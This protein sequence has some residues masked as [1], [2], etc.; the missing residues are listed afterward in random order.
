MWGGRPCVSFRKFPQYKLDSKIVGVA[1]RSSPLQVWCTAICLY[2]IQLCS[3]GRG[4]PPL[5]GW[6]IVSPIVGTFLACRLGRCF[7]ILPYAEVS[8]GDPHPSRLSAFGRTQFAPTGLVHRHLFVRNLTVLGRFVNRPYNL[9]ITVG[10]VRNS[11]V[12]RR[13]VVTPSVTHFVC[14]SR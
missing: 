2:E 10:L 13:F 4:N 14:A 7:C 6:C 8:T 11:T 9:C 5:R 1:E 3:G 12:L